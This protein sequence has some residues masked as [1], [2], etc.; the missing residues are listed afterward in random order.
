MQALKLQVKITEK[1]IL[2]HKSWNTDKN[3]PIKRGVE[4][5]APY[6]LVFHM[7]STLLA[8]MVSGP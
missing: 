5:V 7:L 3:H 2:E 4:D 6:K 1:L 8:S